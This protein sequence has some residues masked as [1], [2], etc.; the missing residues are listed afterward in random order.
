MPIP[1]TSTTQALQRL[2]GAKSHRSKCLALGLPVAWR[3]TV[4]RIIYG[5]A[6]SLDKENTVRARLGLPPIAPPQIPVTPCP[7]CAARGI[8][9]SHGDGLDCNG[10]GGTAVV[11]AD[12]ETVRRPGTPQK[13][14]RYWRP[15]LS[16]ELEKALWRVGTEEIEETLWRLAVEID[17][18][19]ERD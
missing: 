5:H 6:V 18:E 14:K 1:D 8:T 12:G 19:S 9:R 7:S 11:L 2:P 4:G 3:G 17:E 15:C 13:R 10:N 16:K